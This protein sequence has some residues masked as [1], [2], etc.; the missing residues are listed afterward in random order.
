MAIL[1]KSGVWDETYA[2]S[3]S[4]AA[5]ETPKV[6]AGS[7]TTTTTTTAKTRKPAGVQT[8]TTTTTSAPPSPVP[9]PSRPASRRPSAVKAKTPAVEI[10]ASELMSPPIPHASK[11]RHTS[12]SKSKSYVNMP[13]P[14]KEITPPPMYSGPSGT[15][16][17]PHK[18]QDP[19][20]GTPFEN[21]SSPL[22][23]ALC[24]EAA[25]KS[26]RV[27]R[28]LNAIASMV[29][30]PL[31]PSSMESRLGFVEALHGKE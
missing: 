4:D 5:V 17:T 19:L 1:R 27:S 15:P 13:G 11:P 12:S 3:F 25:Q 6:K 22:Y 29:I 31:N 18:K 28:N 14:A 24:L 21:I 9:T 10:P 23:K 2:S 7:T 8:T 20:A 26:D 30:D 16:S